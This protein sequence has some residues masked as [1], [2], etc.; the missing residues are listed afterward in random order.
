MGNMPVLYLIVANYLTILK[1]KQRKTT[2][3]ILFTKKAM[4]KRNSKDKKRTNL[5]TRTDEGGLFKMEIFNIKPE[6]V[7]YFN[8]E[9]VEEPKNK[10]ELD[11]VYIVHEYLGLTIPSAC[12]GYLK[13]PKLPHPNKLSY[14]SSTPMYPKKEDALTFAKCWNQ[15]HDLTRDSEGTLCGD[16][17][18]AKDRAVMRT[19]GRTIKN[20]EPES[21]EE[22]DDD[23]SNMSIDEMQNALKNAK[24]ELNEAKQQTKTALE[25]LAIAKHTIKYYKE[26]NKEHRDA[27]TMLNARS[28]RDRGQ[29][30]RRLYRSGLPGDVQPGEIY[31]DTVPQ[32][33]WMYQYGTDGETNVGVSPSPYNKRKVGDSS[34]RRGEREKRRKVSQ[35]Q[36][37]GSKKRPGGSSERPKRPVTQ[38]GGSKVTQGGSKNA[39]QRPSELGGRKVPPAKTRDKEG[40]SK[41]GEKQETEQEE[42]FDTEESGMK[43]DTARKEAQFKKYYK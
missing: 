7:T 29:Q 3:R 4:P 22:E 36:K 31:C 30:N 11:A 43:D 17:D 39:E 6:L 16:F 12:N 15:Q 35:G 41:P 1:V 23:V 33:H 25:E 28:V 14:W 40:V 18:R 5:V 24:Y 13:L 32:L 37:G 9:N 19:M 42:Y 34:E 27:I 10:K 26:V 21:E 38:Q 8:V 2:A 20:L